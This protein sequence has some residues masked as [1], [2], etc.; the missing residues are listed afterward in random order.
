MDK[1]DEAHGIKGST[2]HGY[3]MLSSN[4]KDEQLVSDHPGFMRIVQQL[5]S[6][7]D[8]LRIWLQEGDVT[9]NKKGILWNYLETRD[10]TLMSRGQL[11][12]KVTQLSSVNQEH[13]TLKEAHAALQTAFTAQGHQ[14]QQ[15]LTQSDTLFDQFDTLYGYLRQSQTKYEALK[16]EYEALKTKNNSP[17]RSVQHTNKMISAMQ[18]IN[19]LRQEIQDLHKSDPDTPGA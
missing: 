18:E 2:I 1:M 11:I 15:A 10:P 14:L 13:A 9:T 17:L 19:R 3:E 7:K 12:H 16:T 5:N 4:T 8:E 6:N